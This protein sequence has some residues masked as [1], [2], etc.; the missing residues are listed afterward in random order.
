[1]VRT[2]TL[3][4]FRQFFVTSMSEKSLKL[5]YL[6]EECWFIIISNSNLTKVCVQKFCCF[7]NQ[8]LYL[9][10]CTTASTWSLFSRACINFKDVIIS[11][12]L[13]HFL[14]FLGTWGAFTSAKSSTK[15]P[16]NIVVYINDSIS[17]SHQ[18]R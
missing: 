9:Y 2:W 14:V 7:L 10:F 17:W 18:I 11:G 13:Q 3:E 12:F 6:N 1:M 8:I 4:N 5:N 16:F 15:P